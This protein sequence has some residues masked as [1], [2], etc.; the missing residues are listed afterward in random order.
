MNNLKKFGAI[1]LI[2]GLALSS[3]KKK[4]EDDNTGVLALLYAATSTDP[5][6]CETAGKTL[7]ATDL[8]A[9][10]A[11]AICTP[12]AGSAKHF[13]IEG[14]EI[15]GNVFYFTV[16]HA[17]TDTADT[18]TATNLAAV[19]NIARLYLYPS[20]ATPA[21]IYAVQ[22]TPNNAA[23]GTRANITGLTTAVSKTST[24]TICFDVADTAPARITIWTTGVNGADCTSP[25]TLTAA[26]S[27]LNKK[28]W[29]SIVKLDSRN[30]FLG[31]KAGQ[32]GG[33]AKF[34]KVTAYTTLAVQD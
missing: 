23:S 19:S 20:L 24:S 21:P 22:Y 28:D 10:S 7:T 31:V 1:A 18:I 3:C 16:G 25:L 8:S 9:A 17:A 15:T 29:N 26:T 32:E 33:S 11:T 34:T 27:V 12:T 13:R 5:T 14:L 4:E 6:K 2:L 30:A